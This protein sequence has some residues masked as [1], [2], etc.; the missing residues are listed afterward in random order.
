MKGMVICILGLVVS[1]VGRAQT[2]AEWFKQSS[3]RLKYYSQ[4]IAALQVYVGELSKEFQISGEGLGAISDSKQAELNLHQDYYASL[5]N[6]DPVVAGM[7]EV[8]EI[9]ALQAA[10]IQRLSNALTRYRNDGLLGA[11]GLAYIGQVYSAVLQAGVEDVET[12]T[13]VLTAN[14]WQMTDGQR[15]AGIRELDVAM[16]RRYE[17][18]IDF[19]DRVDVL[20]RHR[21]SEYVDIKAALGLYGG[22]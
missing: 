3:T 4:Q 21:A 10:I 20:E 12:L 8:G 15:I 13:A 19:T 1:L 16:R 17:F 6:I 11:D 9:G 7:G 2:F 5:E 14:D 22:P 18:A